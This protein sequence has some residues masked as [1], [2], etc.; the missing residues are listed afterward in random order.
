MRGSKSGLGL[1][2][3]LRSGSLSARGLEPTTRGPGGGT[4]R[5]NAVRARRESHA[6]NYWHYLR[7]AQSPRKAEAA[8]GA[9]PRKPAISAGTSVR[10]ARVNLERLRWGEWI[11]AIAAL[12]LL[13]VTF[14]GWYSISGGGG[15]VTAWDAL[16]QGRYLLIATAVVGIFLWLL[17]ASEDSTRLSFAPGWIAAAVGAAC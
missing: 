16:S 8:G 7:K 9:R 15:H 6:L 1:A 10:L 17:Q 3:S 4:P 11:A 14:R 12:D 13:L 5:P 2:F